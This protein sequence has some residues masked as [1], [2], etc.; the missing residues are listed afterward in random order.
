MIAIWQVF[1]IKNKPHSSIYIQGTKSIFIQTTLI[2][3]CL[4][5]TENIAIGAPTKPANKV[6]KTVCSSGCN[7][8]TIQ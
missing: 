7:Y 3:F 5:I 2:L 4:L 8:R 1:L 6:V